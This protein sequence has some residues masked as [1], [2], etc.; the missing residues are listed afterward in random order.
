MGKRIVARES[1]RLQVYKGRR[2]AGEDSPATRR[3]TLDFCPGSSPLRLQRKVVCWQD[4]PMENE[5]QALIHRAALAC[6]TEYPNARAKRAGLFQDRSRHGRS[7]PSTLAG[8]IDLD[9]VDA[10]CLS[11]QKEREGS[12]R[13]SPYPG[14]VVTQGL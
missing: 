14:N 1:G 4:L 5:A 2:V 12:R 3:H 7:H 9:V 6:G 8:R 11:S 13:L 10:R